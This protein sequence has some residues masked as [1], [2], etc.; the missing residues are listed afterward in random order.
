M[1]EN[2]YIYEEPSDPFN[3]QEWAAYKAR[4]ERE[5]K[6]HPD[7]PE[8]FASLNDANSQLFWIRRRA[9]QNQAIS[10]PSLAFPT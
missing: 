1:A 4:M 7:R 8:A 6:L 2:F 9:Q 3:E 10:P 5:V